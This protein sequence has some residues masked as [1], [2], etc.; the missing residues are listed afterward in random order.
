MSLTRPTSKLRQSEAIAPTNNVPIWHSLDIERTID[1]LESDREGL[2]AAQ[3]TAKKARFGA[4]ELSAKKGKPWWLN[5]LLQFNQP[6]LLILLSAG[7]I[8]ALFQEWV[9]ARAIWGVTTTNATISFIQESKA[10]GVIALH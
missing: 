6:L 2:S 1:L 5:F 8:K 4:N 3:V 7:V 9:N 10:E